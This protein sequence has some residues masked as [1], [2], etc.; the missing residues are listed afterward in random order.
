MSGVSEIVHCWILINMPH[1]AMITWLIYRH[2]ASICHTLMAHHI[3]LISC[4]QVGLLRFWNVFSSMIRPTRINNLHVHFLIFYRTYKI[5]YCFVLQ[6]EE[7]Q[8]NFD[9]P[10]LVKDLCHSEKL[11]YAVHRSVWLASVGLF[12]WSVLVL[13]VNTECMHEHS[14]LLSIL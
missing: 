13:Q 5:I 1:L 4:F 7:V 8:H 14:L 3:G 12:Q 2:Y 10:V 9:K 11:A 6:F